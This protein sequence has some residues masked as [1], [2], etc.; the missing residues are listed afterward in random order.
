MDSCG[1]TGWVSLLWLI[2]RTGELQMLQSITAVA[3]K[4][5]RATAIP[6]FKA[7]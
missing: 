6:S 5:K 7:F 3:K 1:L 4:A 2:L